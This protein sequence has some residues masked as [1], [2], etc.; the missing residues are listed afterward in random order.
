MSI[1]LLGI[2][3]YIVL[4]L[5]L[6]F[7]VSRKI[8]TEDDYLLAGRRLGYL[9]ATFSIFATWFGA[10]SCIGTAGAVYEN[11]IAGA[12]SD[13]FGYT[14]CL[15]LMGLFFAVPLWRMKLTTIAD[16]FRIRFSV[17]TERIITI[18]VVPTSLLWAAAQ[19]RAFGL[20]L[21]AS[22]NLDVSTTVTIAAAVV[23]VYTVMG[24]LLADA[25][26]DIVQ[27]SIVIGGLVILLF[28]LVGDL[29][30]VPK[31]LAAIS[32]ERVSLTPAEPQ[33][34]VLQLLRI[35]E[36]WAVPV[37]G[38]VLAQEMISR[39]L[40][41]RSAHVARRSSLMAAGVYLLVGLIPFSIGLLGFS[42][43]PNLE[44]PEQILPTL[45]QRH[46]PTFGYI[47]F[48]GAL[49][50]AILSTVDSALLAASGI[51]CH[52]ILI[53]LK[54]SI[55]EAAKVRLQRFGVAAIGILAYTLA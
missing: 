43:I 20:V 47:L 12:T 13:P 27:G 4:Q 1:L 39:V 3:L 49:L 38:S 50:S 41:S 6:G 29:G 33:P 22:S 25:L 32:A 18:I 37:L 2:L 55:N 53:P 42:V 21:S 28:S 45:A 30:G 26:T 9:L 17:A 5:L 8:R 11:G 14:L 10:E 51:L 44:N 46:L 48:A 16:F 34:T 54:P 31:A 35:A 7:I 24:G 40:S 23:I 19:I 52:N 15:L 36:A